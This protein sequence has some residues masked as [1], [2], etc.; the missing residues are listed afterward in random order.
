M[1]IGIVFIVCVLLTFIITRSYIR[2]VQNKQQVFQSDKR[3][4]E[5]N[6]KQESDKTSAVEAITV[7]GEQHVQLDGAVDSVISNPDLNDNAVTLTLKDLDSSKFSVHLGPLTYRIFVRRYEKSS[8][9]YTGKVMATQDIL[10]L[11]AK[12][13]EV[14][15]ELGLPK[16]K[17][18]EEIIKKIV[19][20]SRMQS[21]QST[22]I[23]IPQRLIVRL[24]IL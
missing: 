22:R 23:D 19:D 15:L 16:G 14:Q 6:K 17:D 20:S 7:R 1:H 5:N 3:V 18:D 8:R 9:R 10:P 4:L 24:S 2:L 13:K 21:P 12:D 11:L